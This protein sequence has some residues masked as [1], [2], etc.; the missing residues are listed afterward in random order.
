M[1][2]DTIPQSTTINESRGNCGRESLYFSH[3]GVFQ[4]YRLNATSQS[5]NHFLST[6]CPKLAEIF[7]TSSVDIEAIWKTE[8]RTRVARQLREE[9][10]FVFGATT[11]IDGE[12]FSGQH[13]V[14]NGNR[15]LL[16]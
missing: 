7:N 14:K 10:S 1:I 8:L 16:F 15:L 13:Q 9:D 2:S 5:F 11:T 12:N 4:F 3:F 6:E